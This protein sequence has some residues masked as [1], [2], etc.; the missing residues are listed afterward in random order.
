MARRWWSTVAAAS[1]PPPGAL[2]LGRPGELRRAATRSHLRDGR[3]VGWF[4]SGSYVGRVALDAELD[5]APPPLLTAR[6][7]TE[8][9]WERW[10]RVECAAKLTRVPIGTWLRRHGLE[11]PPSFGVRLWT[12]RP[13]DLDDLADHERLVVSIGVRPR[14]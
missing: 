9:F 13:A 1:E 6:F 10:T 8:D 12:L 3:C 2:R 5:V 14:H 11:V 7:G 4:P